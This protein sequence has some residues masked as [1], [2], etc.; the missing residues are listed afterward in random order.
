MKP[1]KN[2][3]VSAG[4]SKVRTYFGRPP[5]VAAAS[6]PMRFLSEKSKERHALMT[7]KEMIAERGVVFDASDEHDLKHVIGKV[8]LVSFIT[9]F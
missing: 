7:R 1:S 4:G 9:G 2:K 5:V 6:Q 3:I 8:G